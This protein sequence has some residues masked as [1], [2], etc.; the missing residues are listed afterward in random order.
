MNPVIKALKQLGGSETTEEINNKA[1]EIAKNSYGIYE[2][3][4]S[5]PGIYLLL[6]Q[7]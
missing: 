2:K 4:G 6:H 3:T 7:N 5:V 1:A